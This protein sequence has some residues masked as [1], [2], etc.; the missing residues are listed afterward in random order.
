MEHSLKKYFSSISRLFVPIRI[1]NTSVLSNYMPGFFPGRRSGV[2]DAETNC[3]KFLYWWRSTTNLSLWAIRYNAIKPQPRR[4]IGSWHHLTT[5]HS[6]RLHAANQTN[7]DNNPTLPK[8][9]KKL[10]QVKTLVNAVSRAIEITNRCW[11]STKRSIEEKMDV[12]FIKKHQ[13]WMAILG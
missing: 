3:I 10:M 8:L 2:T 5:T 1:Q 12:A 7:K 9:D 6:Q 4:R 13:N 11:E